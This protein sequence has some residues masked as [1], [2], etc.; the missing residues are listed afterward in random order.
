MTA[1]SKHNNEKAFLIFVFP[2]LHKSHIVF[3]KVPKLYS[4][5]YV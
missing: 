1:E 3:V 2:V 4:V 5:T